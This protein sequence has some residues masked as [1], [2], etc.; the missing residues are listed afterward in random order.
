M[1][2]RTALFVWAIV[3]LLCFLPG[4]G[5]KRT[6]SQPDA[7]PIADVQEG[8]A[9]ESTTDE[10]EDSDGETETEEPPAEEPVIEEPPKEEQTLP[11]V[12]EE[13]VPAS[14]EEEEKAMK[15][16]IGDTVLTVQWEENEAAAALRELAEAGPLTISMSRYGGFEQVGSLGTALPRADV[17]ITTEP[18]DIVLYAG[19]QIV[20]FYGSNTWAY[21]R[22]GHIQGETADSLT[23]LLSDRDVEL[24]L[25]LD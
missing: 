15:L 10:A 2:K 3:L 24:T 9:L 21:T 4:C 1:R 8:A 5:G 14:G 7:E 6:E 17:R 13:D 18:G 20:V 19:D 11:A 25:I 16:Q 23:K 12:T 22:L